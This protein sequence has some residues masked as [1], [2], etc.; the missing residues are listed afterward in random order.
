M[1]ELVNYIN[2]RVSRFIKRSDILNA[3]PATVIS[4]EDENWV[5][6]NILS[7]GSI[8]RLKNLSGSSLV[9]GQ[10][11]QVYYKKNLSQDNAFI[12]AAAT[13]ESVD[14]DYVY[15]DKTTG[16]LFEEERE[17]SEINFT[18]KN[19][20]TAILISYTIDLQGDSSNGIC[21][22]RVRVD[23]EYLERIIRCSV[24][25]GEL[26]TVSLTCPITVDRG[27]HQIIV[28]GQGDGVVSELT[29][30]VFGNGIK[31]YNVYDP[32]DESDYIYDNDSNIIYYIGESNKPAVPTTLNGRSVEK[33]LVTGFNYGEVTSA[34]IPEGIVEIE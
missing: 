17:V 19:N 28:V 30:F 24:S 31:E 11:C 5:T 8:Y 29:S 34:Y 25:A 26:K 12:G 20:N 18:V 21:S 22:F 4:V 10:G 13:N 1:N 2:D 27:V 3:T 7:N 32:T 15:G 33:I 9:E 16:S 14:I 6:I 23:E